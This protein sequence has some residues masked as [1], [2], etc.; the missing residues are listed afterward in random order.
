MRFASRSVVILILVP[1]F[2]AATMPAGSLTTFGDASVSGVNVK[3]GT[4]VFPGDT[5]STGASSAVFNLQNGRTLQI[6]PNSSMRV[7]QDSSVE[8]VKG[9][10]RMQSKSQR[11]TMVA[12]NWRLQGQPDAKSGLLAA[13]VVRDSD[14]K[15]AVNVSDGKVTAQ[16]LRGNVVMVAEA[17]RPVTLPSD[18][19]AG[20]PAGSPGGS[21][22]PS[23]QPGSGGSNK[24]WIVA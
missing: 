8:I 21:P 15:V 14:V 3:S 12:S 4:A 23:P 13:D 2:I 18:P 17:G 1:C 19:S 6:G 20:S 11:F 24:G 16:S 5:I 7:N 10:S 22:S 9:M